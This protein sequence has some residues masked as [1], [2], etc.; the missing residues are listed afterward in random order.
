MANLDYNVRVR[1]I[2]EW[3]QEALKRYTPPTGMDNRSL[4]E[5]MKLIVTDLNSHMPST[6]NEAQVASFL[7]RVGSYVR[8]NQGTRIWPTI[9]MF[10]SGAAKASQQVEQTAVEFKGDG[11]LTTIATKI[12][13]REAIP[14][15]YLFGSSSVMLMHFTGITDNDL[16]PY[17]QILIDTYKDMYGDRYANERLDELTK[18]H[19][20]IQHSFSPDAERK[21]YGGIG[22]REHEGGRPKQ[23]FSIRHAVNKMRSLGED[24]RVT[25]IDF[26]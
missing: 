19:A 20:Q 15:S 12:K 24:D 6:Y 17:R 11:P 23:R 8:A 1:M 16:E 5:E 10:I 9:K 14:D 13:N 4:K 3:L 2:A 7:D 21:H 18:R 25:D 26:S 22:E